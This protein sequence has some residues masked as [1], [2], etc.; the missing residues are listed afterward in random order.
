MI[1]VYFEEDG[2]WSSNSCDCCEPIY[3]GA[4][5]FSCVEGVENPEQYENCDYEMYNGT[6]TSALECL[7]SV[8]WDMVANQENYDD[9]YDF[10]EWVDC[11]S[12]EDLRAMLSCKD[13][14]V[15]FISEEDNA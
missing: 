7:V 6:K 15:I 2:F 1:K 11:V 13:I 9:F 8:F 14:E 12:Y 5:N 4:W 10:C 3:F